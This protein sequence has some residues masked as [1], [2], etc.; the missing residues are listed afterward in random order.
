MAARPESP[1]SMCPIMLL[2]LD[3]G[4]CV[5]AWPDQ[6]SLVQAD[7][8]A[9]NPARRVSRASAQRALLG[10]GDISPPVN[11]MPGVAWES[12]ALS[13]AEAGTASA[14]R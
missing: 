8:A 6:L 9:G 10:C 2:Q 12:L 5:G 13:G 14:K 3:S 11:V 7:Q 1:Q 4:P